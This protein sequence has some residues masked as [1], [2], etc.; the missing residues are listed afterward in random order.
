MILL[1]FKSYFFKTEILKDRLM[2]CIYCT[3]FIL[4][5]YKYFICLVFKVV[6]LVLIFESCFNCILIIFQSLGDEWSTWY[7]NFEHFCLFC[8]FSNIFSFFLARVWPTFLQ[9]SRNSAVS[10]IYPNADIL[11]QS[12]NIVNRKT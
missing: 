1:P 3:Y 11:F 2:N 8:R 12:A 4:V 9:N 5:L 7:I 6:V 10:E